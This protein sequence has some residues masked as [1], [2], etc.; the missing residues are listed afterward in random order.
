MERDVMKR[1][2]SKTGILAGMKPFIIFV[3]IIAFLI[4]FIFFY[5]NRLDIEKARTMVV[6]SGILFEMLFV[7]N[8]KSEKFVFKSSMNKYLIYA[9]IISIGLHL[10]ALY[11]P[12]G[13]LF[14]FVALSFWDWFNISSIC[15]IGFFIVEIFKYFR[16]RR[17]SVL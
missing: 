4:Q 13:G 9:V 11:T 12:I 14:G 5:I 15:L 10:V 3:G 16:N 6:T 2:P 7:F 8:C 1:K 17:F